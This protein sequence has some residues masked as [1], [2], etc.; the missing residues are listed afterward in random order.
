MLHEPIDFDSQDLNVIA[1]DFNI[2]A[3]EAEHLITLMKQCFTGEGRFERRTFEKHIP[4]FLKYEKK[5]FG[6]LWYYLKEIRFREDRVSY[7]NSLQLLIAEMT[8]PRLALKC[9]LMDFI[10]SPRTVSFS[11]RNALILTNI[12][13]RKYNKELNNFIENTPEEVLL[14]Q[15]GLNREMTESAQVLIDQDHERYLQKVRTLHNKLLETIHPTQ[16][17]LQ[18]MTL[19]YLY[20]VEREIFILFSLVGG[21]AAHKIMQSV[22]AEY[23][24]PEAYIYSL[25]HNQEQ[26]KT[27]FGL[28]QLSVRGLTRFNDKSDLTIL[29]KIKTREWAFAE[30]N[31]EL[32]PK[33]TISR[34]LE[35]VD[36]AI[37]EFGASWEEISGP[38]HPCGNMLQIFFNKLTDVFFKLPGRQQPYHSPPASRK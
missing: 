3:K 12:L 24:N 15:E 36:L 9:L 22:V 4:N 14:V 10:H 11:D 19:R 16:E 27:V 31:P 34:V 1:R 26:M 7:L 20:T 33:E 29:R 38:L 17:G 30:L 5:I 37:S 35:F 8:Q 18:P 32:L 25:I 2:S 21:T 23:G 13:L 6:F 28:L